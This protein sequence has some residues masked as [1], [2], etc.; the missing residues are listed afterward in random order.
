M[1]PVLLD[2]G[3]YQLR[4]YGVFVAVAILAG[5]WFAAREARRK[6]LDPAVVMDAAWPIVMAGLVGAR[7]YY[8]AFSAPAY[9]LAH[10]FEIFAVWHGGLSV[11]GALLG[12]L[13]AGLWHIRRRK[14]PFW[15]FADV[16]APGFILGQTVGQIACLLNGD[17]YGR[18][19]DLPWAITFTDPR[20]MAPLGVPLHPIQIYE[21]F[22][23][24][25][26]FLVVWQVS[27]QA[28]R[29]GAVILTY[30]VA[31]GIVRFAIEF[32]RGDPPVVA[33]LVV[34]QA[35]S[36][37]LVAGAVAVWWHRGRMRPGEVRAAVPGLKQR[38]E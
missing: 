21:L 6:G 32:F 38:V 37:L 3:F 33:G 36:V 16:V 14:L 7:L 34:P 18:P 1:Y 25:A 2:L 12:G 5:I 13:V 19:T 4:S 22:A 24:V 26:V 23:Y 20:A 35:M 17:T 30:A 28:G 31:Y 9:Y 11:H 27:G 29:D 8:I 15:K 10:P